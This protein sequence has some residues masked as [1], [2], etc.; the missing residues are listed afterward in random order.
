MI[1]V[2]KNKSF[3][4]YLF[5]AL[6]VAAIASFAVWQIRATR[7]IAADTSD[8]VDQI[9]AS[10]D[11]LQA[12]IETDHSNIQDINNQ[13]WQCMINLFVDGNSPSRA[14]AEECRP[15]TDTTPEGQD[16]GV[17]QFEDS[18]VSSSNHTHDD[19][20]SQPE[21]SPP[22]ENEREPQSPTPEPPRQSIIPGV[23]EP[24]LGC[25]FGARICI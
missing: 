6:G 9:Q 12:D 1:E 20:N 13:V 21:I 11:Q 8:T 3:L 7:D 14:D 4:M 16:S 17:S 18:P 24:W 23:D 10:L 2:A 5:I 22:P 15:S 25:P 19:Q